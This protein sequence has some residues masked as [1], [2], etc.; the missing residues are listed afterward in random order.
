MKYRVK[1]IAAYL[2]IFAMVIHALPGVVLAED[3]STVSEPIE[4]TRGSGAKNGTGIPLTS[5]ATVAVESITSNG[6]PVVSGQKVERDQEIGINVGFSIPNDNLNEAK[7]NTPWTISLADYCGDGAVFSALIANE[8]GVFI[9]K[10]ENE[11]AGTYKVNA[12]GTILLYPDDGWF[13]DKTDVSGT[14]SITAQLNETTNSQLDSN[15]FTFPGGTE[16]HIFFRPKEIKADKFAKRYKGDEVLDL[17]A[18][19]DNLSETG[20]GTSA[21]ADGGTVTVIDAGDGT[22]RLF[23]RIRV[24]VNCK[25]NE[26]LTLTDTLSGG[27][28]LMPDTVS[29]YIEHSSGDVDVP[30]AVTLLDGTEG[31]SLDLK[32]ALTAKFGADTEQ[33]LG[34]NIWIE[35]YTYLTEDDVWITHQPAAASDTDEPDPAKI[36][37]NTATV[38]Y[39]GNELTPSTAVTP[40]Y[41]KK[42]TPGKEIANE[43]RMQYPVTG[44]GGTMAAGQ[45]NEV[46]FLTGGQLSSPA[47]SLTVSDT[48]VGV[49]INKDSIRIA[50]GSESDSNYLGYVMCSSWPD[51]HALT[52]FD[53]TNR[54]SLTLDVYGF[55]KYLVNHDDYYHDMYADYYY[56]A[57]PGDPDTFTL[58]AGT[59][60]KVNYDAEVKEGYRPGDADPLPPV[61]NSATWNAYN[62]PETATVSTTL[63]SDTPETY[64]EKDVYRRFSN[65]TA[66]RVQYEDDGDMVGTVS[67]GSKVHFELDV[68][69]KS[70][71]GSY[72]NLAGKQVTDTIQNFIKALPEE[73]EIYESGSTGGP[74]A[75]YHTQS[76]VWNPGADLGFSI[77]LADPATIGIAEKANE[78]TTAEQ[79]L[80]TSY[81]LFTL[82]FPSEGNYANKYTIGYDV[83]LDDEMPDGDSLY[84]TGNYTVTNT[85]TIGIIGQPEATVTKN[86]NVWFDF[87]QIVKNFTA[88]DVAGNEAVWEILVTLPNGI[89]AIEQPVIITENLYKALIKQTVNNVGARHPSL[90]AIE[91]E[92]FS[93][94]TGASM[95]TGDTAINHYIIQK[96]GYEAKVVFPKG[97]SRNI[98]IVVHMDLSPYTLSEQA[99]LHAENYA[100]L[101]VGPNNN[102]VS[103]TGDYYDTDFEFTKTGEFSRDADEENGE[104]AADTIQWEVHI[105]PAGKHIMPDFKPVFTDTIPDGLQRSSSIRITGYLGNYA[106]KAFMLKVSPAAT[107]GSFELNLIDLINANWDTGATEKYDPFYEYDKPAGLSG[108]HF[109]IE[110]ETV[111][112]DAKKQEIAQ[113]QTDEKLKNYPFTNHAEIY[114]EGGETPLKTDSDTVKYVYE[115]LVKKEDISAESGGAVQLLSYKVTVNPGKNKINGGNWV[116][117]TDEIPTSMTLMLSS[118]T[119][120]DGNGNVISGTD[121]CSISYSDVTRR[122][123][124][125]VPDQ[126][127]AVVFFDAIPNGG[128]GT[129]VNTVVLSGTDFSQTETV[130]KEHRINSAGTLQG[131]SNAVQIKKVDKYSINTTLP[132]AVFEF[133]ECGVDPATGEII[134]ET[135]TGEYTSN[136]RGMLT[137]SPVKS[138]TLYYWKEIQAPADYEIASSVPHYFVVYQELNSSNKVTVPWNRLNSATREAILAKFNQDDYPAYTLIRGLDETSTTSVYIKAYGPS[139]GKE[140]EYNSNQY[141]YLT[142]DEYPSGTGYSSLLEEVNAVNRQ[143]ADDLDDL[144][145]D[146]YDGQK[147]VASI[148]NGYTWQV[149]NIRSTVTSIQLSASKT[150]TGR[151]MEKD[152]FTFYLYNETVEDDV[153][154]LQTQTSPAAADGEP[155]E[156]SF[157][158]ISYTTPGTYK[159]RIEEK[160][161]NAENVTYDE[162]VYH[163]E[164]NVVR[165]EQEGSPTYG[166]LVANVSGVKKTQGTSGTLTDVADHNIAFE[167]TYTQPE[168]EFTPTGTKTLTGRSMSKGEFSFTVTEGS[169]TVSTGSNAAAADGQPGRITFTPIHYTSTG[170]HTYTVSEDDISLSFVEQTGTA[171]YTVVVEVTDPRGDGHLQAAVVSINGGAAG[172]VAFTNKY[173]VPKTKLEGRKVW[174]D[175]LASHDNA[176]LI[177]LELYRFVEGG[178]PEPY[179]LSQVQWTGDTFTYPDL[180]AKDNSNPAK[181]Y[182]YYVI[183]SGFTDDIDGEYVTTYSNTGDNASVTDKALDGGTITNRAKMGSLELTK[184]VAGAA[185]PESRTYSFLVSRTT[186]E[187]DEAVTTYFG[188][189]AEGKATAG[190]EEKQYVELTVPAGETSAT[191]TITDLV[192]GTYTVAEA[193]DSTHDPNLAGYILEVTGE[194][195]ATVPDG[196][197]AR[198]EITNKYTEKEGVSLNLTG[199]K[200]LDGTAAVTAGQFTFAIAKGTMDDDVAANVTLPDETITNDADGSFSIEGITFAKNGTYN[201]IVTETAGDDETIEYDDETYEITVTVIETETGYAIS[202]VSGTTETATAGTYAIDNLSGKS[203]TFGNRTKKGS[204]E[205]TKKVSGAALP[206]SRTYSFL[207]S[208]TTGEGDEAVTTY[209]GRD[210]DGKATAGTEE[211]QYVELTVPAGETSATVTITDLVIGTY[212]VAEANDSTHDPNLAGYILEV[213]GE[214]TAT[215]PDGDTARKEITNTYIRETGS[216]FLRKTVTVNGT[217][218]DT[219]L[220]DETYSFTVAGSGAADGTTVTVTVTFGNGDVRSAA[221]DGTAVTPEADGSVKITGLPTGEY[222]VTEDT[223]GLADKGIQLLK[224]PGE[225]ITV[226]KDDAGTEILTAEFVN[227]KPIGTTPLTATKKIEGRTFLDGDEWTFTVT[228]ADG[229]PMPEY[230]PVV[231]TPAAGE[232]EADIDFGSIEYGLADAGKTYTYTITETGTIAGVT[233]DSEEKTVTVTIADNGDGTLKIENSCE[234]TP[235]EFV[236][237]YEA[238]GSYPPGAVKVLEGRDLKAEEFSFELKDKDGKVL[239]T[240]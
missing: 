56:Y 212:T 111:L 13:T 198:K 175:G 64:I 78:T 71:D 220:A 157:D 222:T 189:D 237:T 206:E 9:D 120:Q 140:D 207:V 81:D 141:C 65:G 90:D 178:E 79:S 106:A 167:N 75:T 221:V 7:N 107:T 27:Q 169:E 152:E 33:Y 118:V 133:Y 108:W 188:R 158:K 183:E 18:A 125:S 147:I 210:A 50:I 39:D 105:N 93:Q 215:V 8:N 135:K 153:H 236:N 34:K 2:L 66:E 235:V 154:W 217:A 102:T 232:T 203:A 104:Q 85:G 173:E 122:L 24:Q 55:I 70:V 16:T 205:L 19:T 52:S 229:T 219:A 117:L 58:K 53:E 46:Y 86:V 115:D 100:T 179:T 40:Q 72:V 6:E 82:T 224:E 28:A 94:D 1:K 176:N 150:L 45:Q 159:Y 226:A 190:M 211:K 36:Q 5:V 12:D 194:G 25:P 136:S 74:I 201:L 3:Y 171:S 121:Q 181:D 174:Q 148:K 228:A 223:T 77:S 204:L 84:G 163:I 166:E 170:I 128:N 162:T 47:T 138:N 30:A 35:Y 238:T 142:S 11:R 208:R 195:T 83:V 10:S 129:Y 234:T 32:A 62:N 199:T 209:F 99:E 103:A 240:V 124:I 186:G 69:Q 130:T 182:T 126:M 15:S 139:S 44:T 95:P 14:F 89:D 180:P 61:S 155:A 177:V 202:G 151:A 67:A 59:E 42:V 185:L 192:I 172:A 92:V 41:V 21:T 110:Y 225:K 54:D 113:S 160:K 149:E 49:M 200:H 116:T 239:E 231:L 97:I 119:V 164:I 4:L 214:G 187:G 80:R 233:N 161:G 17:H 218:T 131:M 196:D 197:T 98:R 144:V 134:G 26:Q 68:Y 114:K 51:C 191:V 88:W 165:D 60:F 101:T 31:F 123:E 91:F 57:D 184:K 230:N 168:G 38:K 29:V 43:E 112:T 20:T 146:F 137:F 37:T 227:N 48:A 143:E 213:T 127:K 96:S 23:Y 145:T 109:K 76:G 63:T 193:N 87:P 216:I 132:G 73:I 156:V 22:Y